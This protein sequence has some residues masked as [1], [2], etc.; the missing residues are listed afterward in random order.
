MS[1]LNTKQSL[2]YNGTEHVINYIE[3]IS[4]WSIETQKNYFKALVAF[5]SS[6]SI[7]REIYQK[8]LG[9][10]IGIAQEQRDKNEKSISQIEHWINYDEIVKKYD[11]LRNNGVSLELVVSSF[12]CGIY[13]APYWIM[14][15]ENLKIQNIDKSK[16]NYIDFA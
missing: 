14:E 8:E 1:R 6:S 2:F 11:K 9:K 5:I 13:F 3:N 4:K 7:K 12:Y 15:L 10:L 16:D